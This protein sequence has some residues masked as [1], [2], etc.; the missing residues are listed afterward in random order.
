MVV[1]RD[2]TPDEENLDNLCR[3]VKM[4]LIK[5]FSEVTKPKEFEN[6]KAEDF[7]E[8]N[9]CALNHPKYARAQFDEA[10]SNLH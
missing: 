5:L 3:T 6:A 10:V 8:I 1:F 7:F 9:F 2:F 4:D